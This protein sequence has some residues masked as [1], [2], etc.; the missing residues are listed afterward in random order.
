MID[1]CTGGKTDADKHQRG[2]E[3]RDGDVGGH[4]IESSSARA[5]VRKTSVSGHAFAL[6]LVFDS[7]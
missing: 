1:G 6:T 3:H 2:D 5:P 7:V 4:G